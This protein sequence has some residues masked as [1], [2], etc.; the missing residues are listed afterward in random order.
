MI[1]QLEARYSVFNSVESMLAPETLSYLL[2]KTITRAEVQSMNGHGGVAGSYMDYVQTNAERLVLKRM[3]VDHDWLMFASDDYQCRSVTLW[4]YGLLDQLIPHVEHKIIACARDG[5]GWGILMH[6]LT[7]SVHTWGDTMSPERVPFFLDALA[8]IHA[9]FWNDHSLQDPQLGL[10][11]PIALLDNSALPKARQHPDYQGSAI[12]EWVRKGWEA[13]PNIVPPEVFEHMLDLIENPQPLF[14]ALK[15]Y[16]VT[17][18]H[19]DYRAENLAFV[20]PDSPIALDWQM[21]AYSLM[22]ID[23]AWFVKN[24]Y[25]HAAM[26]EDDAICYY[27]RRLESYLGQKFDNTEWQVMLD[28]GRCFEAMRSVGICTFFCR[29][30]TD[31]E[32]RAFEEHMLKRFGQHVINAIPL[33]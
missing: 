13:L 15:R 26:S 31:P 21:S 14:E 3:S 5:K 10:C 18:L 29:Q 8:R 7:G 6:D 9:T 28:L 11:S 12:P 33:L 4:Q 23:L 19:G 32:R 25:V 17:L 16:P 30:Q 22:T 24:D 27:R 1:K 2:S 20:K